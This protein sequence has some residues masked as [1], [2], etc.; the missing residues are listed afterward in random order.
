MTDE[1][2]NEEIDAEGPSDDS[3]VVTGIGELVTNDPNRD[4]VLGLIDDATI[5]IV[6]GRIADVGHRDDVSAPDD[7]RIIDVEGR[8]VVPGFVDAH[9]HAVFAGDRADEFHRRLAGDTYEA[10]LEA[11]GGIYATVE[12]TRAA[13]FVELIAQSLPRIRRM[14]ASGTTTAEVKTGYGLDIGTELAMASAI[15]A[16]GMSLPVDLIPTFLGAHVVAPEYVGRPDDYLELVTGEMLTAVAPFVRSVDVFCDEVAFDVPQAQQV[17]AAA[18]ATGLGFRVHADQ[19]A[20]IGATALAAEV[21]ALSADHLD[22]ATDDDLEALAGAGTAGVFL[23]GV[24]YAMRLPP[25]DARRAWDAGVTVALATD[26]NP[27]TS[28]V[29][30]MPFVISL[31]VLHAGL[32]VDEA[33]WAATAGGAAALGLDDRGQVRAGAV[34]D[35]VVLDAPS[36]DHLGYRPDSSITAGVIKDGVFLA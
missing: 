2:G 27:G 22:H 5:A 14:V 6:D 16:I 21:S 28:W 8:A 4:G 33:V 13:G 18:A 9:T 29:E 31:A 1:A 23:P 19:T 32:R 15:N 25:P 12:A 34:G 11:G 3:I 36:H 24:S 26:C 35:L 10:I 30:T 7:V 20:R 17:A